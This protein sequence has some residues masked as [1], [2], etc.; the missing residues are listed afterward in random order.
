MSG[1]DAS[2]FYHWF[3]S[4]HSLHLRRA[5]CEVWSAAEHGFSDAILFF[6]WGGGA[7]LGVCCLAQA[8]PTCG[9][10]GLL[11]LQHEGFSLWWLLLLQN[12]GS[13]THRLQ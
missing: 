4:V 10:H 2:S 5:L 9:K 12:T 11:Q 8:F 1:P 3:L 6:F 13:K 7:I